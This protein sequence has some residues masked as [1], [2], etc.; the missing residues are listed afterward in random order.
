MFYLIKIFFKDPW[1][2]VPLI[3]SA[4][5]QV[6]MWPYI[7]IH[8][9]A[10]GA[11]MMFLHYNIIFGVDYVGDWWKIFVMPGIGLGIIILNFGGA[12]YSYN[13]DKL[14]SRIIT[15]FTAVLQIFLALAVY[16]IVDINL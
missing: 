4:L 13:T 8:A 2:F 6:F 7:I 9:G 10:Q 1:V 12:I 5:A 11:G 16:L 14:L 15:V 3:V